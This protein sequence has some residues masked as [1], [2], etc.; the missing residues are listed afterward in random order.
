MIVVDFNVG[1]QDKLFGQVCLVLVG[2][3]Y[4]NDGGLIM[5]MIGIVGQELIVQGVNVM[6][7]NVGVEGF[8]W[9]VVCELLCSFCINVVSLIVLIEFMGVYGLFFF[10]FELIMVVCVVLVYCCSVEGVQ[11]GWVYCVG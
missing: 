11:S 4:L 1:L 10:G 5:F 8:V 3:Y 6:V 7:V 2:Q 9:V